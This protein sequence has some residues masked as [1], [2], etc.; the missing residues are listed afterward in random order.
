VV[1]VTDSAVIPRSATTQFMVAVG[2]VPQLD[3][4]VW[5]LGID[6]PS[7]AS[8]GVQWGEFSMQN[9]KNDP[10]PGQVSR[11]PGDPIY[12][13]DPAANPG[14]DDDFY[15]GGVFPR[16]FNSL[17]SL[18]RVPYDEPFWA[19]ERAHTLGDRTNRVH[20]LL[21]TPLVS[22]T[23]AF[24]LTVDLPAGSWSLGGVT[25]PG[26]GD[27]DFVVA[28]INGA[29]ARTVLFSGRLSQATN[30]LLNFTAAQVSATFGANSLE[31][32]RVGPSDP[33]TSYWIAYDHLRLESVP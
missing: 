5:Q 4:R 23:A 24:R 22:A 8:N 9:Q 15:F 19:W 32:I 12:D 25:Q 20:F 33:S 18:L 27:H 30:L 28:F 13:A 14:P 17:P 31:L 16:G 29:G 26:F 10:R 7:S 2:D 21:G 6:S 11:L 3:R 1:A